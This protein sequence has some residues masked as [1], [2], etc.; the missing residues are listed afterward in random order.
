MLVFGVIS[1]EVSSLESTKFYGLL[2]GL[3]SKCFLNFIQIE[4]S[5]MELLRKV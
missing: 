4:R 3:Q 5:L 1:H 2:F